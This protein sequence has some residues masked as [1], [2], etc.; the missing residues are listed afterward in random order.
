MTRVFFLSLLSRKFDDRLSSNFHRFVILCICW[1]TPTVKASLWQ[2]P[3][4][5]TAF[6]NL[7]GWWPCD[8][9]PCLRLGPL[10]QGHDPVGFTARAFIT[11][12]RPCRFYSSGLYH[13]ATTLSVL[14][15]GPLSQGHDPVGFTAQAFITRPRPCRF[16]S[17]GLYHKATT[18]SVLQLRPLSQGHDPVGFTAR[19]FIALQPP[20]KVL[21][22]RLKTRRLLFCSLIY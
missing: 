2:L 4:V 21:H 17:S 22:G 3:I 13:K 11:R 16:Y 8:K 1:D 15:L 18:L 7:A 20:C 5:S 12:P 14:Q 9:S 6:K 19:G 10:S